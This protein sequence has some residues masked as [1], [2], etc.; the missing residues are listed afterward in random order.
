[1]SESDR[2]LPFDQEPQGFTPFE[3]PMNDGS[4]FA[5]NNKFWQQAFEIAIPK[6]GRE[7]FQDM[8]KEK[9]A[10]LWERLS[11]GKV[12]VDDIIEGLG[13]VQQMR[14]EDEILDLLHK[15]GVSQVSHA[16][17]AS[18]IVYEYIRGPLMGIA[19]ADMGAK[20]VN[21]DDEGDATL[22]SKDL[23]IHLKDARVLFDQNYR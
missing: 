22:Y 2:P 3:C 19:C 14:F 1:M 20:L 4:T 15:G 5:I 12:T 6:E 13:I 18:E 10:M 21:L 9:S 8:L 17:I 16:E 7:T 11:R 23:P